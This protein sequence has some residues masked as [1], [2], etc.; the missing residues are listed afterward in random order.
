MELRQALISLGV[1]A[2]AGALI[3][4]ERQQSLLRREESDEDGPRSMA[5]QEFGGIRTFPLISIAGALGA[6]LEPAAGLWILAILLL[7]VSAL[8]TVGYLRTSSDTDTGLSTEI[9]GLITFVLGA[10]AAMPALLPDPQRYLLVAAGAAVVMVLLAF[11][12]PLHGFVSK[13]RADDVYATAKFVVFALFVLPILPDRTYGPLS[14]LNPFKVGIMICL[15]AGVSFAGYV[16]ARLVGGQLGLLVTGVLGGLVSSTATTLTF[17]GRAKEQ[18]ALIASCAIAILA[19]CSI[20]FARILVMV[21]VVDRALLGSVVVSL[22]TMTAVGLLIAGALYWRSSTQTREASPIP[23]RNPFQLAQAVKFGLV[24]AAVLF[25][26]KAAQTYVG[27][28]GVLVSALVAGST[29]ADAIVLS[30]ADLHKGGL[31]ERT[32]VTGITLAA[33]ANTLMKAGIAWALGGRALG[34][35]VG[36]ALLVTLAAGGV[37]LLIAG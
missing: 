6:M 26:A 29:D 7:G 10:V 18:P 15:V 12:R 14:V 27:A 37:A 34:R 16:A 20:M 5:R 33:V 24:Y 19:A 21:S 31:D 4:A 36:G 1:A 9:A 17:S 22:G 3:G 13:V 30:L 28:R 2:A 23:L 11:K 35:V 8:L 32:A 25:I